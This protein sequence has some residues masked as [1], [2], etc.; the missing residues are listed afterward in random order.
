MKR[1][2]TVLQPCPPSERFSE[3]EI[4]GER[5][6]AERRRERGMINHTHTFV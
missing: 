2:V 3:M 6:E 5:G 4:G 1:I